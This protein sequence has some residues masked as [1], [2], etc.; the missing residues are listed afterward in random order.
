MEMP[1]LSK[2]KGKIIGGGGTVS[3]AAVVGLMAMLN[4]DPITMYDWHVDIAD[5][6]AEMDHTQEE[7][8]KWQSRETRDRIRK[9]FA[10][11]LKNCVDRGGDYDTCV[12][13]VNAKM[14][15]DLRHAEEAERR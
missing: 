10:W 5:K 7:I 1:D 2:H 11:R 14:E 8:V 12:R 3:I 9:E 4:V 6:V 13:E 15:G